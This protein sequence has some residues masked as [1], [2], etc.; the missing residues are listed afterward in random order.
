VSASVFSILTG[1]KG[2]HGLC[3]HALPILK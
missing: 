3:L 2:G 1:G